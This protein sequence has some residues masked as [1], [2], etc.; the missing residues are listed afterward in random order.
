MPPKRT[1]HYNKDHGKNYGL[2]IVEYEITG[3]V[4][5]SIICK[6]SFLFK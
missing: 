1:Y 5:N 2:E 4:Y 3:A 6:M